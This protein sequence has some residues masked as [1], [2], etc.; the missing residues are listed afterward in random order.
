MEWIGIE[1]HPDTPPDGRPLT[2]LFPAA[3]IGRMTKHL[4]AMGAPYGIGFADFSL[5]S[6]SRNAHLAALYAEEQGAF[7]ALHPLLFSAYF[8]HGQ[9]IGDSDLLVQLGRDAGIAEDDLRAA[10]RDQRY[11][12]RLAQAQEEAIRLGVTGVP[13]CFIG[14]KERIVGAQPIEVFRKALKTASKG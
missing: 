2:E 8:S 9:D 1:I 14:G 6:N 7:A 3:D 11:V 10:L 4:R 5:L 12:D 13:T